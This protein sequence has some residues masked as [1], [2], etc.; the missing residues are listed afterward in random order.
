M[1]THGNAHHRRSPRYVG[2][3]AFQVGSCPCENIAGLM[4]RTLVEFSLGTCYAKE[5][6]RIFGDKGAHLRL[7]YH[8]IGHT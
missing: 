4:V 2:D 7:V 5:A 1:I 8:V 6:K 3:E